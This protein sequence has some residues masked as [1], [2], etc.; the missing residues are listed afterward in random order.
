MENAGDNQP[1]TG[2]DG[3][4]ALVRWIRERIDHEDNLLAQRTTWVV[5]S[6]AFL[7]SAYAICAGALSPG[8]HR[9]HDHE[10]EILL[11]LIPS[12]AIGSLA[13][14]YFTIAGALRAT[15]QLRR[16]L[17]PAQE[18]HRVILLGD[19]F[20]QFAGA[21]APLFIPAVFLITWIILLL[22]R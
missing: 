7:F 14:L 13:L 6:Q 8:V 15:G 11:T 16:L 1:S 5:T 9:P 19:R 17:L 21:S 4:A 22:A 10:L 12:A 2:A 18:A 3:E 20:V